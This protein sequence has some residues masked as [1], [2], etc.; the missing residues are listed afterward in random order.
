MKKHGNR[1]LP[2]AEAGNSLVGTRTADTNALNTTFAVVR[3]TVPDFRVV[4]TVVLAF[5]PP[6]DGSEARFVAVVGVG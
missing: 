3:I 2:S 5:D 6:V 4:G 1:Q